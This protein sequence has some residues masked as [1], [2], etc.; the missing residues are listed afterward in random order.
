MRRRFGASEEECYPRS[1]LAMSAERWIDNRRVPL[2][3][4]SGVIGMAAFCIY[5]RTW[6][7][8]PHTVYDIPASFAVFCFIG[9][10]LTEALQDGVNGHWLARF[11][12]LV[13]MTVV[14]T[15]RPFELRT[16]CGA[17]PIGRPT[18]PPGGAAC[19]LASLADCAGDPLVLV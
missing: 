14:C 18:T 2:Q 11:I 16:G 15:G 10:L 17:G 9:Q 7:D 13:A 6:R 8:W 4:A 19:I 3:L 1:E 5:S 12:L